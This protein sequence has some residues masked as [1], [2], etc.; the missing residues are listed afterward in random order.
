MKKKHC[1]FIAVSII[2]CCL[3]LFGC[4]LSRELQLTYEEA[5]SPQYRLAQYI[6]PDGGFSFTPDQR[7]YN[8]YATY[9]SREFL[10]LQG[11]SL[12]LIKNNLSQPEGWQTELDNE[13]LT[14]YDLWLFTNVFID[15][16]LED[17]NL[18]AELKQLPIYSINESDVLSD[19]PYYMTEIGYYIAVADL[20]NWEEDKNIGLSFAQKRISCS[21]SSSLS[22]RFT[23]LYC[24]YTMETQYKHH[25]DIDKDYYLDKWIDYE[26]DI[27]EAYE[28]QTITLIALDEYL[29]L[30][31]FLNQ[32]PKLSQDQIQDHLLKLKN[33]DGGFGL[34]LGW[35]SN[36]L[37]PYYVSKICHISDISLDLQDT[38]KATLVFQ[39]KEGFFAVSKGNSFPEPTY[40]AAKSMLYLGYTPDEVYNT[41]SFIKNTGYDDGYSLLLHAFTETNLDSQQIVETFTN[42]LAPRG[43]SWLY[44]LH[45]LLDL[46][47]E[48]NINLTEEVKQSSAATLKE[49]REIVAEYDIVLFDL[50]LN[51]LGAEC[52]EYDI[53]QEIE[54]YLA[55]AGH[56]L[57]SLSM[58]LYACEKSDDYLT[59]LLED[60]QCLNHIKNELDKCMTPLELYADSSEGLVSY[61]SIFGGLY[62][63]D[64][65]SRY[66]S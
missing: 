64:F 14:L 18:I 52:N 31:E 21:A 47:E 60:K 37:C 27:L 35:E 20:L 1:I 19:T 32:S 50:L 57:F 30:C 33:A 49:Y 44:K 42:S 4:T 62:I 5:T 24:I 12:E 16:I 43:I 8:L 48:K 23:E 17:E 41:V 25:F 65:L 51:R 46:M 58:Y 15:F 2:L 63:E 10:L 45:L 36:P 26:A 9:Y 3:Y 34:V 55:N 66:T 22:E 56:D 13:N 28:N 29:G 38:I 11:Y 54:T 59:E 61:F 53:T 39:T 6:N 40:L 7:G